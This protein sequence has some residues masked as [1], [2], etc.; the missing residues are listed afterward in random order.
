VK[1]L[2]EKAQSK[3][4]DFLDIISAILGQHF[5]HTPQIKCKAAAAEFA[6]IGVNSTPTIPPGQKIPPR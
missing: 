5:L 1:G 3:N 2:I 6:V 4:V